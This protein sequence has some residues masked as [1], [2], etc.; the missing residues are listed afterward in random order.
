MIQE[1]IIIFVPHKIISE[2]NNRDHWAVKRKRALNQQYGIV[3]ALKNKFD[4]PF[5]CI[6]TFERV[7]KKMLDEDNLIHAFKHAKDQVA[8]LIVLDKD[9]IIAAKALNSSSAASK[10][11]WDS[12]PHIQWRYGQKSNVDAFGKKHPIGFWI[13]IEPNCTIKS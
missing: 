3:A 7:G 8:E 1:K 9:P 4:Y 13:T 6:V 10:G 12:C 5:P 2:A 11:I